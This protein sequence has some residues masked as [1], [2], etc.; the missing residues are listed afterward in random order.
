MESEKIIEVIE[1]LIGNIEPV[2]D[3]SI[4]SK[5]YDNM[6]TY[7]KVFNHMHIEIDRIAYEYSDSRYASAKRIG[8]LASK[9]I[10][11]MGI[12]E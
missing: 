3:S 5:R 8:E 7:I 12:S 11:S 4:D 2:A 9:H 1:K 10:D 6:E